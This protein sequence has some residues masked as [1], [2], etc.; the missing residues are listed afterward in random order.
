MYLVAKVQLDAPVSVSYIH[1]YLLVVRH[2]IPTTNDGHSAPFSP[3]ASKGCNGD[4]ARQ[5]AVMTSLQR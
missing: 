4:V 3:K 1:T 5:M 2:T